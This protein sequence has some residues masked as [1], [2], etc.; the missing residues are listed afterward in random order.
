VKPPKPTYVSKAHATDIENLPQVE[1][2]FPLL[3]KKKNTT[4]GDSAGSKQ[5][6]TNDPEDYDYGDEEGFEDEYGE[7][8]FYGED[9]EYYDEGDY[10]DEEYGEEQEDVLQNIDNDIR[11]AS[12][13]L[14]IENSQSH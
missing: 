9:G 7:E 1:T 5:P 14:N 3:S 12:G 4:K 11:P 10:D 13:G 6:T 8:G 2:L